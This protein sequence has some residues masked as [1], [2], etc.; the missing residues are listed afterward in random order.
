VGACIADKNF[1]AF[2]LAF[3]YA[4]VYGVSNSGLSWLTIRAGEMGVAEMLTIVSGVM[5]GFM[6]LSLLGMATGFANG[7][8]CGPRVSRRDGF[9]RMIRA[10]GKSWIERL[11]PIQRESTFLAWPDV[12]WDG[13]VSF[14]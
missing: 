10:F 9:H 11:L 3:L 6:G 1:K 12:D 2:I 5:S 14:A 4:A 13:A 7:S 8:F